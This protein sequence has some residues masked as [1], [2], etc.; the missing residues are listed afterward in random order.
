MSLLASGGACS[1][2]YDE[3]H[4][5]ASRPMEPLAGSEG[6]RSRRSSRQWSPDE[7]LQTCRETL[8]GRYDDIPEKAFYFA[9][10]IEEIRSRSGTG[11]GPPSRGAFDLHLD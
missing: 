11:G 7:A 8:E 9:G 10:G 3:A 1:L 6:Y 5:G 2:Q 4:D